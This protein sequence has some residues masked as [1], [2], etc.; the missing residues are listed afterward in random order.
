MTYKVMVGD[1]V[2]A[3]CSN[4]KGMPALTIQNTPSEIIGLS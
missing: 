2:F 4:F 3:Y 1:E